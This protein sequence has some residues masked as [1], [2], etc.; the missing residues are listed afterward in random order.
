[1][2]MSFAVFLCSR[3]AW[4]CTNLTTSLAHRRESVTRAEPKRSWRKLRMNGT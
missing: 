2:V 4:R 1:M 3:G